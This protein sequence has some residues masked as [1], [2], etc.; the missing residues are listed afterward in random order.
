MKTGTKVNA[1]KRY[2]Q[3]FW[4]K[5]LNFY[6]YYLLMIDFKF[7]TKRN[8]IN[9]AILSKKSRRRTAQGLLYALQKSVFVIRKELYFQW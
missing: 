8:P 1:T 9:P 3:V 6:F 2:W 7:L 4:E 5:F